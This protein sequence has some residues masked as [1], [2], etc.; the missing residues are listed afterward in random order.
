MHASR[1]V[2]KNAMYN[3]NTLILIVFLWVLV[4]VFLADIA[5]LRTK[6]TACSDSIIVAN[7]HI[8]LQ[9]LKII[10]ARDMGSFESL[11]PQRTVINP[12]LKK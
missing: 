3:K 5:F 7:A 1:E 10:E 12:C 2:W 8:N 6:I 4:V 9:N 11:W